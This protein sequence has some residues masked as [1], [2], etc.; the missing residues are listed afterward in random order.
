MTWI[1]EA[2][3]L[4]HPHVITVFEI[5]EETCDGQPDWPY[6]ASEDIP[7]QDVAKVLKTELEQDRALPPWRVAEI[8]RKVAEALDTAQQAGM[9]R[10]D[11][12]PQNI[13]ISRL[14]L[15]P[16]LLSKPDSNRNSNSGRDRVLPSIE[17]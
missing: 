10:C 14:G 7:S 2:A 1:F 12:N 9:V 4:R 6:T 16:D 8:C 5:G 13:L 3:R 17:A 15:R 11:L